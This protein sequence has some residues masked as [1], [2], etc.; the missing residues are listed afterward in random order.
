MGT[1][2][3]P[4]PTDIGPGI[5]HWNGT[6]WKQ[7]PSSGL[8]GGRLSAVAAT[9]ASNAWAV[10][11]TNSGQSLILHWDGTSWKQVPS[12][13]QPNGQL[14]AMAAFSASSVWRRRSP[15]LRLADKRDLLTLVRRR[16]GAQ[17]QSTG[18]ADVD[19]TREELRVAA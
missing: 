5:A 3:G 19:A 10:G 2:P 4:P 17:A 7:V 6:S 18:A 11:G 9:S 12:S 14:S 8:P 13:G 1:V 16:E 15:S